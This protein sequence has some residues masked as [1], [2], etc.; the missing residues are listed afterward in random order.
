MMTRKEEVEN[1]NKVFSEGIKELTSLKL[2]QEQVMNLNL[3]SIAQMLS[4]ISITLAMIVDQLTSNNGSGTV[5]SEVE[6]KE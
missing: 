1:N 6:D 3:S 2:T 4:D 5:E